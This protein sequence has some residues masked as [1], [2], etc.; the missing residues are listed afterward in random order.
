MIRI[1][2]GVPLKGTINI[3]GAKNSLQFAV[4]VSLFV[5]T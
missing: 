1:S 3:Q 4:A 5:D 2:G